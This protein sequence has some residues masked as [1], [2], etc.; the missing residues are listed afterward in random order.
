MRLEIM[1]VH[2]LDCISFTNPDNSGYSSA[3]SLLIN[4][5]N[6]LSKLSPVLSPAL[7]PSKITLPSGKL[8]E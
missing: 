3:L 7:V 4:I 5:L 6:L 2:S 1:S 8:I